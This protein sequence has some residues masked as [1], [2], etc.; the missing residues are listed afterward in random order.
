MG[1]CQESATEDAQGA[2][3]EGFEVD[4]TLPEA[5]SLSVSWSG[6]VEDA[7]RTFGKIAPYNAMTITV[8]FSE[9]PADR[10]LTIAGEEPSGGCVMGSSSTEW[11]CTHMVNA[12]TDAEGTNLILVT[13][14][15]AAGNQASK[16][17]SLVYDFTGPSILNATAAPAW[18]IEMRT[19]CINSPWTSLC[20]PWRMAKAS[21][22]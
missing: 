12:N 20:L 13:V 5:P 10:R 3:L 8:Q 4:A 1:N 2:T 9:A 6:C 14:K 18:P 22:F 21:R 7:C 17:L 15:D 19:W 16:D 11:V